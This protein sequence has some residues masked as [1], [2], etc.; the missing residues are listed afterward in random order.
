MDQL[1]VF[2]PTRVQAPASEGVGI[3]IPERTV[4]RSWPVHWWQRNYDQEPDAPDPRPMKLRERIVPPA[5]V[6]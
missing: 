4:P 5:P 2:P 3:E 6:A 1:P